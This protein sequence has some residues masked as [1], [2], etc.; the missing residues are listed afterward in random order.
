MYYPGLVPVYF[1][2]KSMPQLEGLPKQVKE[3]NVD[4]FLLPNKR[5]LSTLILLTGSEKAENALAISSLLE[6]QILPSMM[7]GSF[8][9]LDF[10][11]SE[12]VRVLH[13]PF[14]G[15]CTVYENEVLK[16]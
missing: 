13:R 12:A 7:R 8:E 15:Y 10:N 11:L 1:P 14:E 16:F 5:V 3:R 4:R 2:T 6:D 9:V